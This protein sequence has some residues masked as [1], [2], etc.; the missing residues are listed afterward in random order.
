[1]SEITQPHDRFL[2]LLLSDPEKADALLRERLPKEIA[3]LLSP[4]PPELVEGSFVD[5]ELRDHLTDRL[6]RVRTLHGR[7]ALLYIL[8]DHKSQTALL[9]VDQDVA[10]GISNLNSGPAAGQS[11]N[12]WFMD[13]ASDGSSVYNESTERVAS[14]ATDLSANPV[15]LALEDGF[16]AV[17]LAQQHPDAVSVLTALQSVLLAGN[18]LSD[19]FKENT[20]TMLGTTPDA[21]NELLLNNGTALISVV[22]AF[23]NPTPTK[24][25]AA[26]LQVMKADL[27]V[28]DSMRTVAKDAMNID[29][30]TLTDLMAFGGAGLAVVSVL[31]NPTPQNIVHA[32]SQTVSIIQ[33]LADDPEQ[34]AQLSQVLSDASLALNLYEFAKNPNPQTAVSTLLAVGMMVAPEFTAPIAAGLTIAEATRSGLRN[35]TPPFQPKGHPATLMP[36]SCS[37]PVCSSKNGGFVVKAPHH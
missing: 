26:L 24:I 28:S 13:R 18:Y 36:Y 20:A 6:F 4:D 9:T 15:Q 27:P 3:E 16:L 11:L 12:T 29:D 2:K 21:V 25:A 17:S 33:K 19:T 5:A 14:T 23:Q 30:A 8:I 34:Y 37:F 31:Q 32:S 7:V 22:D 10:S 1:M 35:R